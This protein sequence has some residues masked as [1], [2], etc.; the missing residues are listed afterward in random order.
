MTSP[1]WYYKEAIEHELERLGAST[2][3]FQ[4]DRAR[5]RD[6][7]QAAPAD[8]EL[9][10]AV[11]GAVLGPAGQ[12]L[13]TLTRLQDGAGDDSIAEALFGHTPFRRA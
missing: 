1:G 4:D 6:E 7:E 12:V 9:T 5:F 10:S 2:W 13:E 11:Y 3:R 8:V